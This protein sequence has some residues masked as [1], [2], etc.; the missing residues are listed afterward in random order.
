MYGLRY[1]CYNVFLTDSHITVYTEF[2]SI[3][4]SSLLTSIFYLLKF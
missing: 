3:N 4:P 1:F 2:K